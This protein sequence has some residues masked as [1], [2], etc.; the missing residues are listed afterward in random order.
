L[1]GAIALLASLAIAS[2]AM[3]FI[4]FYVIRGGLEAGGAMLRINPRQLVENTALFASGLLFFGDTIWVYVN[5]SKAVLALVGMA[6]LT[7]FAVIVAG[8]Y[9]R[10]RDRWMTFM[11][12]GLVVASFPTI[13]LYHVSEMYVPPM[14]LP[15]A[16]LSA[17]AADALVS[18]GRA[19][20]Y[21]LAVL[22]AAALVLSIV[23]IRHKIS[24]LVEVGERA[25]AQLKQVLA[26]IAPD[27]RNKRIMLL[28]D[29]GE[30]PP[31]RTYSVFRMGDEILSR[32]RPSG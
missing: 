6:C 20:R 28:F 8:L 3:I 19:M 25:D 17:M 26:F 1:L 2:L 29:R 14:L 5:Q 10:G 4:R 13:L 21:M 15:F 30:L 31:R 12:I 32:R 22:A 7:S 24:G 16:M 11:L 27:A 9:L 18:R 23:T